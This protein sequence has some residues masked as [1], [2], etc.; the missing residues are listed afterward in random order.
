MRHGARPSCAFAK[1]HVADIVA[2]RP[3][4]QRPCQ[5]CKVPVAKA[6]FTALELCIVH[7]R[8]G[9]VADLVSLLLPPAAPER[10]GPGA[11]HMRRLCCHAV[12]RPPG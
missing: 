1:E 6:R 3:E 10:R 4:Q 8:L 9:Q 11:R 12:A 2:L 7:R 5:P